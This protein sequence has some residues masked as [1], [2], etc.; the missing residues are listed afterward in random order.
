MSPVFCFGYWLI[1]G[2]FNIF[3]IIIIKKK[4]P[5]GGQHIRSSFF[6]HDLFNLLLVANFI[7][8]KRNHNKELVIYDKKKKINIKRLLSPPSP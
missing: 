8:S 6:W 5:S 7:R 4:N 1:Y 2:L 3:L